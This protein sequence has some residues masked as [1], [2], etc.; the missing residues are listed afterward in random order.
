MGGLD[1]IEQDHVFQLHGVAHHA[2]CAHQS[3]A[4]DE[5]AV[6]HLRF[7]PDDAGAA[8]IGRGSHGGG[9]MHPHL[10]GNFVVIL[11]RG[12]EGEDE[13]LDARQRLPGVGELREVVF[14]KGVAQVEQVFYSQHDDLLVLLYSVCLD[15]VCLDKTDCHGCA[16]PAQCHGILH[17]AIVAPPTGFVNMFKNCL[18]GGHL[19][20]ALSALQY[21]Q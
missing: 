6:A 7:R 12:A 10:G 3:A 1:V 13:I 9:F 20:L 4:A 21:G 19:H 2:V 14:G 17:G 8:Q 18:Q 11:Q 15:N 16:A 5:G